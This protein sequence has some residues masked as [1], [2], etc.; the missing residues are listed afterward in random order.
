MRPPVGSK[1]F[2]TTAIKLAGGAPAGFRAAG[3]EAAVRLEDIPHDSIQRGE[4]ALRLEG[5]DE[6]GCPPPRMRQC[7]A[8]GGG[9]LAGDAQDGLGRDTRLR[10]PPLRRV[11]PPGGGQSPAPEDGP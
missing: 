5:V 6:V 7:A 1:T 10:L 3:D 9:E 8:L 11:A 4:G 2:P